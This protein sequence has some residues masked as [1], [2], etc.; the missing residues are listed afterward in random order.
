MPVGY[1]D[2]ADASIPE[3]DLSQ[4]PHSMDYSTL[5]SSDF[6]VVGN[7]PLFNSFKLVP[8]TCSILG[9]NIL[10]LCL[11]SWCSLHTI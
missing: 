7:V 2:I 3:D 4:V 10:S 1:A 6:V 8:Y 9:R 11:V 5:Q